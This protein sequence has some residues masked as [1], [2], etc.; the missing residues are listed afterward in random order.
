MTICL[1]G[2]I[3][4]ERRFS[5]FAS[6]KIDNQIVPYMNIFIK[7]LFDHRKEK[8]MKAHTVLNPYINNPEINTNASDT[9]LILSG[10]TT[11]QEALI[12]Y[13]ARLCY[14]SVGSMGIAPNFI[15]KLIGYG[16]L[17]VIEH[18]VVS[19]DVP[20]YRAMADLRMANRFVRYTEMENGSYTATANMR[21]WRELALKGIISRYTVDEISLMFPKVMEGIVENS[22]SMVYQSFGDTLVEPV[23]TDEVAIN[24][25][26]YNQATYGNE[27]SDGDRHFTFLIEGMS[28][29]AIPHLIRHR[30]GSYSQRSMRYTGIAP[31]FNFVFP[32]SWDKS[33]DKK[34]F[35]FSVQQ[36]LRSYEELRKLG[37][38]KQDARYIL[39]QAIKTRIVASMHY[40]DWQ[41]FLE[42]RLA[43]AAQWEIR[44]VAQSI[45]D[46]IIQVIEK[47]CQEE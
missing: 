34:D 26:G 11:P 9:G 15:P 22:S 31:N 28:L 39:P 4:L 36:T 29:A 27:I 42:L 45:N 32:K 21:V 24:L 12:E 6:P 44:H 8:N 23:T 25:L 38:P 30:A 16:H 43:K 20:H 33:P 19:L 37:I 40:E 41:R 1:F 17:D 46:M 47:R 10:T 14:E 13:S 2:G 18:V 7:A 3:L 5:S 35:V